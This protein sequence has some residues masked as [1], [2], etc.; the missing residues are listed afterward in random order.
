MGILVLRS[1]LA[2]S[3][4]LFICF[5]IL[6]RLCGL[7]VEKLSLLAQIVTHFLAISFKDFYALLDSF[8]FVGFSLAI[9]QDV[10]HFFFHFLVLHLFFSGCPVPL[11]VNRTY[12]SKGFVHLRL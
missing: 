6:K 3:M 5:I 2:D 8:F 10:Q 9:Y 11:F 12:V 7:H 1:C 4:I